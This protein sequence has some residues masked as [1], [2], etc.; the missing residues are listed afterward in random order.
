MPLE[1]LLT[2]GGHLQARN[3]DGAPGRNARA[4]EQAFSEGTAAGL[5]K[6]ASTRLEAPSPALQ[7]W[8]EFAARYLAARCQRPSPAGTALEPLPPPADLA[9]AAS[10][11][12][13]GLGMEYLDAD[14]LARFWEDLDKHIREEVSASADDLAAWIQRHTPS[15]NA[16]GR[17]CLHLAENPSDPAYPFAFL[18][19]YAPDVSHT[20]RV[21][22]RPLGK[23]LEEFAGARNRK[24][25]AALLEPIRRAAERSPLVAALLES[26]DVFHPL[27]WAPEEA[28]RL[29]REAAVLESAGLLLRLPDWWRTRPR[30][31]VAVN[32]GTTSKGHFSAASLDLNVSLAVGEEI[33]DEDELEQLLDADPGLVLLK[34]RW[35]E[36]DGERLKEALQ[37]WR[38]L[39]RDAGKDGLSFIEGMRL[40]AGAPRSLDDNDLP[41]PVR[42]WSTITPAD[43]L[44]E[45]LQRLRDPQAEPASA[46]HDLLQAELRPYQESGR[47][48]LRLL[49][50]LGL[51][52]CLAD[53]MGLGKTVQVI[54]L[55]CDL[56]GTRR[57]R[58]VKSSNTGRVPSLLV[59]PASLLGNWKSELA[60]FAP[61]LRIRFVHPSE[62]SADDITS[63]A[64][65]PEKTFGDADLVVTTYGMLSRQSWLTER[66]W[67][68]A[69][70]DEAQ[71]IK[72]P[73]TRQT[74]AVKRINAQARFALTGTPVEN[75]LGDLW[76]LFDFLCPGLL[77]SAE[78][79]KRFVKALEAREQAR[80]APLRALVRP[81]ILRRLKT[82]RQR[83]PGSAGQDRDE[84]L[85]R[86]D[87]PPGG[88]LQADRGRPARASGEHGT[89]YRAPRPGAGDP[90]AA[91]ADL[92]PSE[93]GS[94]DGTYAP[95]TAAS[96]RASPRSPRRSRRA[97]R[98]M[99]VFTQFRETDPPAGRVPRRV[100]R[101]ARA[102]CCT[103][104]TAV[105]KRK[106][107][108]C[109]AFQRRRRP[110]VHGAVA[111]GRWR[112]ASTS[113]R[114]PTWFTST[115]GGTPRWRT[116][117]PT[118]RFASARRAT[119]WCTSSS[120]A[121]PSRSVSTPSS[122][123]RRHSPATCWRVV[124][125]HI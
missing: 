75:R 118:A 113:P 78:R 114:P 73:A 28:Y 11:T 89:R 23:A 99:L 37:H 55:L 35:V 115:A 70:L 44:G 16:V 88:A 112:R 97:R 20:G 87:P 3:P 79:F 110:A 46:T 69:I 10:R 85:V 107:L 105:R 83:H 17:V 53:D 100:F 63:T 98:R 91:Q 30:M 2:P 31:R 29:L 19:T 96:S 45:V 38:K 36:V 108:R 18:A 76:S 92:Q 13:P 4:I 12:P 94:D 104:A 101:G 109:D 67:H 59:I 33:L 8:R 82:D 111:Q 6:L 116:R 41:D 25:L 120:A 102:W 34:G 43:T 64:R 56:R 40:L 90:D 68:L 74:R 52:G 84:G 47:A 124:A 49:A 58:G 95:A 103:A 121:A 54:A 93:P 15:W 1:L 9:D 7:F 5:L 14:R 72:N 61:A 42:Q 66:S 48:W 81:Y 119:S 26:G 80:Y 27:A 77:G 86:P 24:A 62:M 71:A 39:K 50:E 122:T 123:T 22:Y 60:R 21:R 57:P 106:R 65:A 32:L 117:P 51:G 125:K